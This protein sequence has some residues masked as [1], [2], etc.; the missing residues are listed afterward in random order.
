MPAHEAD[1]IDSK[2]AEHEE[3]RPPFGAPYVWVLAVIDGEQPNAVHRLSRYE[4]LI[5]RGDG[6]QIDLN[7]DKVSKRHCLIR[8]EGPVCTIQELGSLNGTRV[9]GRKM[10]DETA[11]RLRHLD[12]VQIGGTR[13]FVLNG[14]F[15]RMTPQ[16]A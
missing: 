11:L 1:A 9:N 16:S 6:A 5:G 13:L 7:D 12:E 14:A 3:P 4:T 10:K 15:K 2:T 8:I